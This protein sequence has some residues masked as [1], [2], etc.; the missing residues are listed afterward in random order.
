MQQSPIEI[1]R[2]NQHLFEITRDG[3]FSQDFVSKDGKI[4]V[5][6][7]RV[8]GGYL[9]GHNRYILTIDQKEETFDTLEEV[10]KKIIKRMKLK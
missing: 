6:S 9:S 10:Y 5:K 1:I 7:I 8:G 4:Y 2:N 3:L